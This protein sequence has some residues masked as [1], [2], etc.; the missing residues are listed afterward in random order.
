MLTLFAPAAR[1]GSMRVLLM[2]M[3][4]ILLVHKMLIAPLFQIRT[5]VGRHIQKIHVELCLRSIHYGIREKRILGPESHRGE[6]DQ[7]HEGIFEYRVNS[8]RYSKICLI[9]SRLE[10][11]SDEGS[12]MERS[13]A[14]RFTVHISM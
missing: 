6:Q 7:C 2:Q 3:L 13:Q 10:V 12:S 1:L 5:K 4:G 9:L 11:R 8:K 14:Q